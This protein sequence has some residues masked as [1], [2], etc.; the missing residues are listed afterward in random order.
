MKN[1]K[2]TKLDY[3]PTLKKMAEQGYIKYPVD[4]GH[5]YVDHGSKDKGEFWCFEFKVEY[6]DGCF[7]P[8]VFT[9]EKIAK[10]GK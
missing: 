10:S 4:K 8:F 5:C 1:R 3:A 7:Y 2:W 9:R 6:R